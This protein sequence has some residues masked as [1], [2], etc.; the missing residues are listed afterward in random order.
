MFQ[1][2]NQLSQFY[3]KRA[4]FKLYDKNF[5]NYKSRIQIEYIWIFVRAICVCAKLNERFTDFRVFV[6]PRIRYNK[7][8]ET[9]QASLN[10]SKC[11]YNLR[12]LTRGRDFRTR[13]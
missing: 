3:K 1:N 11:P 6:N 12:E 2:N 7:P 10:S 13:F 8:S 5:K 4:M 9:E